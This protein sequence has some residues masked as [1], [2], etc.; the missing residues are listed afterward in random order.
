M[1]G[2]KA[3]SGQWIEI[4][5]EPHQLIYTMLSLEKIELQFGSLAEMQS[6]ITDDH[7]QVKLDRP[8]VRL[9]I[10]V[11]H[12]GLLH[13]YDD[14]PG[15]RRRIAGGIPPSGL[16]AVVEAFTAAFTDSFGEL[17]A[18]AMSGEAVGPNRADRRRS[19][20]P[21]GTTMRP[22]PLVVPNRSGSA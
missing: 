21:S 7:G 17:G 15:D 19:P 10:D 12:A 22:S 8:V 1:P 2:T 5:G 3:D 13:D 14:T 6:M 4:G 16:E 11:I 9:L 18:R 20:G